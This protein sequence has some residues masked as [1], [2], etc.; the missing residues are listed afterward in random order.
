MMKL[1][2]FAIVPVTP[3]QERTELVRIQMI[4]ERDLALPTVLF[5]HQLLINSFPETQT[6]S[7]GE[8]KIAGLMATQRKMRWLT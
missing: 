5:F 7:S 3:E 1:N 4:H 8:E 2:Q 6:L